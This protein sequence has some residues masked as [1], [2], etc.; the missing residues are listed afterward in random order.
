MTAATDPAKT[1]IVLV[2]GAWHG[3]WCWSRVLPL[4]RSAGVDIHAVTLTG[5]GER[6][7]LLSPTINLDTHIQDVIGLI[8]AEELQR[9]VLVGH[10]YA[11]MV[12]TGVADRLQVERPGLLAH[13]VYLDAALP[14]PGDSWS[15]HHSPETKQ[16]RIDAAQPSG[17]LSFPPP[18]AALFGLADA[19]RDWVNRRQTPQPFRLYQQPLDFDAARVA[20]VPRTFIDCTQPALATIAPSRVRVRSESGWNVVEMATGHDPMVSE[21]AALS[22]ILL[23]VQRRA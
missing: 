17:G 15:S 3:A 23:D 4:L 19:D 20:A 16:A 1:A 22:Q 5:V 8:E 6:A 2:H 10:S 18:D 9:V 7:H 13:L 21:P 12:I 11:G 14:Y